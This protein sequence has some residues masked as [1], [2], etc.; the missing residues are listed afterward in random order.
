[1]IAVRRYIAIAGFLVGAAGAALEE[2]FMVWV[3]IGL[4]A[5]AL[6]LRL[7]AGFRNRRSSSPSNSP[8]ADDE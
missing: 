5:A 3:A 7:I 4:L 1:M 8:S 6:L 2:P